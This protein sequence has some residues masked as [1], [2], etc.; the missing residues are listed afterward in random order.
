M[1]ISHG[2]PRCQTIRFANVI[3]MSHDSTPRGKMCH[4]RGT[5]KICDDLTVRLSDL[6]MLLQKGVVFTIGQMSSETWDTGDSICCNICKWGS[7]KHVVCLTLFAD[8]LRSMPNVTILIQ[9]FPEVLDHKALKILRLI[10]TNSR[11]LITGLCLVMSKWARDGHFFVLFISK[12]EQMS[13][14]LGVKHRPWAQK[15]PTAWGDRTTSLRGFKTGDSES[16]PTVWMPSK[17]HISCVSQFLVSHKKVDPRCLIS[18]GDGNPI[19]L[20][21][22]TGL[23]KCYP[24]R[25][26]PPASWSIHWGREGTDGRLLTRGT[27]CWDNSETGETALQ[28]KKNGAKW[29]P[30]RFPCNAQKE[31]ISASHAPQYS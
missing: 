31:G 25:M 22:S 21:E 15:P 13:S 16:G 28:Y 19:I 27:F 3:V 1:L 5:P 4:K 10:P 23:L 24:S 30:C 26:I 18:R 7:W 8:V 14:W 29:I 20:Q 17:V 2:V 9:E 6:F 12:N 11:G